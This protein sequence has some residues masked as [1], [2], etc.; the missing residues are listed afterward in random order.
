MIITKKDKTWS[1]LDNNEKINA[2][3]E[4]IRKYLETG[5]TNLKFDERKP[6]FDEALENKNLIFSKKGI[7]A[8]KY[9]EYQLVT[10]V[11][12]GD[13]YFYLY[14]KEGFSFMD[15]IIDLKKI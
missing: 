15:R 4:A 10:N 6:I 7:N 11:K 3:K 8:P 12:I 9:P 2:Q 1:E 14:E 5:N 13:T